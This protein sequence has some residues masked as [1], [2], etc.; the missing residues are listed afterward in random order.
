MTVV[1]CPVSW[2]DLSQRLGKRAAGLCARAVVSKPGF[3]LT[4]GMAAAGG[5]TKPFRHQQFLLDLA[6]G[7]TPGGG[8]PAPHGPPLAISP[9]IGGPAA[10]SETD[11]GTFPTSV[12]V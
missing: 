5:H 7:D 9:N 4:D 11:D 8:G 12:S 3:V 6:A 1:T 10:A 2:G